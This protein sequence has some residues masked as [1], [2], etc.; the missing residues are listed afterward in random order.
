MRKVIWLFFWLAYVVPCAA[1]TFVVDQNGFADFNNIQEAIDA[2]SHGDTVVVRPGTYTGPIYFYGKAITVTGQDPDDPN[3]VDSTVITGTVG[4]Y[5]VI[6]DLGASRSSVL[7]GLTITDRGVHCYD[8]SPT[9]TKNTIRDCSG[10]AIYGE[11]TAKPAISYNTIINNNGGGISYCDGPVSFNIISGNTTDYDGGGLY[12]C[13][14]TISY[15]TISGNYAAA[16][17]GGLGGCAGKIIYNVISG[18]HSNEGGGGLFGC[19]GEIIYNVISGN[20]GGYYYYGGGGICWS[21]GTIKNNVICGNRTTR[22]GG[23]LYDCDGTIINNT[24]CWN[25]AIHYGGGLYGCNGPVVKNNIIAFNEAAEGGGI[26]GPWN[27]NTYNAF[28]MNVGGD[29]SGGAAIGTGNIAVDPL[30]AVEGQWDE[31]NWI[32][33]DYH[34]K[35]EAGRW[36]PNLNDWVIDANTSRCIDAGNPASPLDEEP[37]DINNLR[38]N[39]GAYGG[40]AEA[41]KTPGNWSLLADLTNDGEVDF[42]DYATQAQGWQQSET[43]QPGDLNRNGTVDIYDFSLLADDWLKQTTWTQP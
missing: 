15:N 12:R 33:G 29:V 26:S 25:K 28:W 11:L 4:S 24:I 13:D 16:H 21:N 41:S 43:E 19:G 42:I 39:M 34:L 40:T 31:S 17:G 23:G 10:R 36:D 14:G 9:I 20:F 37:N 5:N 35:S 1:D 6:F 22:A 27:N 7:T 8:T 2:S 30:F 38:I 3:I 18:N 32:E